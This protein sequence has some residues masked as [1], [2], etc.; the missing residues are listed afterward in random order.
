MLIETIPDAICEKTIHLAI[1]REHS[2]I[3]LHAFIFTEFH[4][5]YYHV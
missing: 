2:P 4:I 1:E 3:G 5:S